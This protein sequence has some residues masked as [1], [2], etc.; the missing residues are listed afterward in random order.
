MRDL[1]DILKFYLIVAWLAV[2][3]LAVAGVAAVLWPIGVLIGPK[4]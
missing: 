3:L 2:L 1:I 4:F